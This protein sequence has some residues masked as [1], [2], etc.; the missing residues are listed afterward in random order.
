MIAEL[1][2]IGGR[3]SQGTCLSICSKEQNRSYICRQLLSI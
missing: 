3:L 2:Y 1:L